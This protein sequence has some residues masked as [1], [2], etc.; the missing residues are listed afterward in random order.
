MDWT[1]ERILKTLDECCDQFTFPMLDNGYTYLAACRLSAFRADRFW[2]I[3]IEVFGFSPRAAIPDIFIYHFGNGIVR[4]KTAETFV[5]PEAFAAYLQN[6]PHNETDCVEPIAAGDWI[7]VDPSDLVVP[8]KIA[9]VRGIDYPMPSRKA[10]RRLG[11]N[12]EDS[13]DLFV[14]EICRSLAAT[15]RELVLATEDELRHMVPSEMELILQ[16]DEWHHPDIVDPANRPSGNQAFQQICEVLVTGDANQYQP[17]FEPNT[18]W[19][20]WPEGGTL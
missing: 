8:G 16:L 10:L 18:H 9:K 13:Q 7:N 1:K 19:S 4:H 6:N 11:I 14:H 15:H 2:Q 20:N 3:A 17:S 12:P 5:T